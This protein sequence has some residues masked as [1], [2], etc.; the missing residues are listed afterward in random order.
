MGSLTLV[1]KH[2]ILEGMQKERILPSTPYT[3]QPARPPCIARPHIAGLLCDESGQDLIEY[4]LVGALL[5]VAVAAAVT[6]L[7]KKIGTSFNAIGNSLT[8]AV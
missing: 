7:G 4:A 2:Q 6:T 1:P 5:A 8:N 3:A